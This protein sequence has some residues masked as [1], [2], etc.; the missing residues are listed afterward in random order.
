MIVDPT[1]LTIKEGKAIRCSWFYY[2][3]GSSRQARIPPLLLLTCCVC[4]CAWDN[5]VHATRNGKKKQNKHKVNEITQRDSSSRDKL[6]LPL[7]IKRLVVGTLGV[8]ERID[9]PLSRKG[10]HCTLDSFLRKLNVV[11]VVFFFNFFLQFPSFFYII[12]LTK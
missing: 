11:V 5:C 1:Q 7:P 4:V 8:E 9:L 10:A 2:T 12:P 3:I 6:P